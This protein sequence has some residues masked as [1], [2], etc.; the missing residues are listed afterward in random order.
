VDK[1]ALAVWK[2]LSSYPF[3][4][5]NN[6]LLRNAPGGREMGRDHPNNS[7]PV[8][9]GHGIRAFQ[10]HMWASGIRGWLWVARSG[11]GWKPVFT[12][13]Y[14]PKNISGSSNTIFFFRLGDLMLV[15]KTE[16]KLDQY[17]QY[18]VFF[19]GDGKNQVSSTTR[20]QF[21]K[22]SKMLARRRLYS[23]R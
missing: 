23:R 21:G 11:S 15:S 22:S 5:Y 17:R 12:T 7:P 2:S 9:R 3:Y 10:T 14:A 20:G 18:D 8:G 4:S 6:F 13:F 1:D 16:E 19:P